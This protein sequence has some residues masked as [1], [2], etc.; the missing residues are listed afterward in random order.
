[1]ALTGEEP[2]PYGWLVSVPNRHQVCWH[3]IKDATVLP[4]IHGMTVF[5][6]MGFSDSPG[7]VSPHVYWWSGSEY[8]QLTQTD[9]AG[10]L[11][12][13]V[14]PELGAVLQALTSD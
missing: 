13:H 7:P 2:G 1:M 6:G 10:Q 4:V 12:I 3:V 8:Q 9:D 14:G 5:T 11:S